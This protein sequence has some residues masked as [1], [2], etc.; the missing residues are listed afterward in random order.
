MSDTKDKEEK[1]KVKVGWIYNLNKV[2]ISEESNKRGIQVDENE[3]FE[4]IR[5]TLVAAVKAEGSA[6]NLENNA[7]A[8]QDSKQQQT[9]T[10][11]SSSSEDS[12]HSVS[13]SDEESDMSGKHTGLEFCL[14]KDDWEIFVERLE[15]RIKAKKIAETEKAGELLLRLDDDAYKLMRNLCAP[16]KLADTTYGELVKV[17]TNH[18]KPK[19]SELME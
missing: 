18:L 15:I 14:E 16:A 11:D 10:I 12:S 4:N 2:E 8:K 19:P 9:T 13:D 1:E 17:M 7:S 6:V 5:K 3:K